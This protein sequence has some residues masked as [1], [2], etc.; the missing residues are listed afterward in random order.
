MTTGE[1][2]VK[3]TLEPVYLKNDQENMVIRSTHG[4]HG[5]CCG[6]FSGEKEYVMGENSKFVLDA[7]LMG[8]EITRNEY[9]NF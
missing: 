5:R 3:M 6:R 4:S 2:I 1:L 8:D 7:I 9:W